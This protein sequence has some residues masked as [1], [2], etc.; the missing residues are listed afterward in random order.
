MSSLQGAKN[1]NT[2]QWQDSTH[3]YKE[4]Y[5]RGDNIPCVAYPGNNKK[6]QENHQ[7]ALH[8]F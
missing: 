4:I 1:D 2:G 3:F 8:L 6:R 7:L 5:Q